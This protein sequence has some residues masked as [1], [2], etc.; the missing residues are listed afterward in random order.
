MVFSSASWNRMIFE[1][2]HV[3]IE[4]FNLCGQHTLISKQV[5]FH[6]YHPLPLF[7]V[8]VI[9]FYKIDWHSLMEI[10]VK[11]TNTLESYVAYWQHFD[12]T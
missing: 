6:S 1:A 9:V 2:N 11:P 12:I 7:F 3:L 10:D 8:Q 4:V 5:F